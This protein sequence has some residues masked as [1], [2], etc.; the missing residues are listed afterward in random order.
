MKDPKNKNCIECGNLFLQYN[1]LVKVC[2]TKCAI[3]H[4][5]K[6]TKKQAKKDWAKEK[7]QIKENIKTLNDWQKE[8]E[9]EINKIAALID[10]G[11][12]CISCKGLKSPQGGHY[13]SVK[14]NGSIRFNL[15]NIH[16]QDYYCNVEKSA[17]LHNYDLGLIDRYGKQYWEYVKFDIVRLF[18][19]L[20]MAKNDYS[21]KIKVARSIVKHLKLENKTY[22]TTERLELRKKF[23][24][25]IGIYKAD[26]LYF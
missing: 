23:N 21:E 19:L 13:H 18:P 5:K 7:K 25:M 14:A 15:D 6:K 24:A 2:S 17:N 20:K 11:S 8:L 10:F 3:E 1:S 26:S 4:A 9:R 22:N 16:L 12:G